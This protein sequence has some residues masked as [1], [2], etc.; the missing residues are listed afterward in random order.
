MTTTFIETIRRHLGWCPNAHAIRMQKQGSPGADFPGLT[1]SVKSPGP[2]GADRAGRPRDWWY[3]HTQRGSL[4][5]WSVAAVTVILLVSMYLFGVVWVTAFVLAV[6]IA[7][8]ALFSSLTVSVC[9]D[10]LM[11]RFGPVHLI[12]KSW[13]V[14]E[15]VSVTEVINPWYYGWGI[16]IT[17]YGTL[18]NI[19]GFR[20]VEVKL[21]NGKSFRVG[22]DEP[23]TLRQAIEK[24][25]R[26][27]R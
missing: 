16:R 12:K 26:T 7:L 27:R 25:F 10:M 24:S 6:M 17:P 4:I 11:I 3:E 1:A 14:S 15:I 20:A 8:V 13:P 5:L 9:D 22:T 18:Y 21:Q 19:S 2:S 23:E